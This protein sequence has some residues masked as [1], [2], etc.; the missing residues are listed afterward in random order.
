MVAE[1]AG[2]S[3]VNIGEHHGIDYIYS[4][5]PVVL[6]A[7]GERTTTL[8]LG[9]GSHAARQPRCASCRRGLRHARRPLQRTGRRRRRPRQ[10]LRQHVH[11]LRSGRRGVAG[12]LRRGRRAVRPAVD[13]GAAE[14][15]GQVPRRRSTARRSSRSRSSR[16]TPMWIGG[17]SSP[18]TAELAARLGFKLMLPSAFGNPAVFTPDRRDVPRALPAGRSRHRSRRS[19]AAGT[20][21]WAGTVRRR[22]PGGSRAIAGTT[23]GCAVLLT[24]GQPGD[25]RST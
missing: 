3:G 2:W 5:P 12:A 1:E 14:V 9:H 15:D 22:R 7:I 23:S 8:R 4:A 24:A 21:T 16:N 20:S 11:A 19:V 17:G 13:V 6:A 18:E 10:L 25:C